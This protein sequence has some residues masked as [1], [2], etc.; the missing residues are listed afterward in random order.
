V[1]NVLPDADGTGQFLTLEIVES[2]AIPRTYR[3]KRFG[4]SVAPP[5]TPNRTRK[6]N[7]RVIGQTE[8]AHVNGGLSS[9]SRR[10][11]LLDDDPALQSLVVSIC[12]KHEWTW[13]VVAEQ[14]DTRMPALRSRPKLLVLGFTL[15]DENSLQ[16]L[17]DLHAAHPKAPLAIVTADSFDDVADVVGLAGGSAVLMQPTGAPDGAAQ[18]KSYAPTDLVAELLS[19]ATVHGHRPADGARFP[20]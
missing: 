3:M 4:T 18:G 12:E 6:E 11:L 1:A 13:S 19:P 5:R 7:N 15:N 2:F 9:T 14:R 20:R 16:F 8:R 17:H 10:V